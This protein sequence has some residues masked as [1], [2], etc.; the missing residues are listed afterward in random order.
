MFNSFHDRLRSE[1]ARKRTVFTR[2]IRQSNTAPY[3]TVYGL[4]HSTWGVKLFSYRT[5]RQPGVF[6]M[7]ISTSQIKNTLQS[8]W[9]SEWNRSLIAET[10]LFAIIE[11]GL[12]RGVQDWRGVKKFFEN[13]SKTS[14][15]YRNFEKNFGDL[16]KIF[17]D[18][19]RFFGNLWR[20]F[21][22]F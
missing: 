1:I 8:N 7:L 10:K 5:T 22:N 20:I 6:S 18:F 9:K 16:L 13:F 21:E 14:I 11:S 17:R 4:Y 3:T 12:S 15:N 2:N 19:W